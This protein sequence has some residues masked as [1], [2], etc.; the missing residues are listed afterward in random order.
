MSDKRSNHPEGIEWQGEDEIDSFQKIRHLPE[1]PLPVSSRRRAKSASRKTAGS[2]K[3]N[4]HN[5][6]VSGGIQ[7]R[8]RRHYG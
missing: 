3:A 2:R 6:S 7:Q 5:R 1:L 4:K 8:R